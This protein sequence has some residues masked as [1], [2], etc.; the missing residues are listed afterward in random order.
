MDWKTVSV[1]KMV[2]PELWT[3]PVPQFR[4]LQAGSSYGSHNTGMIGSNELTHRIMPTWWMCVWRWLLL[5]SCGHNATFIDRYFWAG[6]WESRGPRTSNMP[7]RYFTPSHTARPHRRIPGRAVVN[8]TP[9]LLLLFNLGT[10]LTKLLTLYSNFL[11]SCLNGLSRWSVVF[12]WE[13][14]S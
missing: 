4:W 9:T 14:S 12:E 8:C 13:W 7:G 6:S 1:W 11:L 2:G 5:C 3:L 10:G